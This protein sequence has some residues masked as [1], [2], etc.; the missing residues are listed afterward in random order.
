VEQVELPRTNAMEWANERE[1]HYIEKRGGVLRDMDE[2]LA[3]TLN[4]TSGGQVGNP[5]ARWEAIQA[6][7][8]HKWHNFQVAYQSFFERE[9]HGRVPRNHVENGQPIGVAVHNI[10]SHSH[11]VEG[12]LERMQWLQDRGWVANE[13][14]ARWID[15]QV[16]YQ[17][18]F[19]REGHGKVPQDH[20]ENGQ[21][22]GQSV[23]GIRSKSI[24]VKGR[25]E[26][27]QWLQ[28]RGW[29]ASELDA[30]WHDFQVAYQSFFSREGHGRVPQDHVENGQPIGETVHNIRSQSIFVKGRPERMQ[31]LTERGW[32]ASEL[33]AQWTDFQ[34]E[35]DLFFKSKKHGRVPYTYTSP[36]GYKLGKTVSNIRAKLQFVKG[37]PDRLQWLKERGF[38]MHATN[39]LK[40]KRKW[41]AAWATCP[42]TSGSGS[43]NGSEG[44]SSSSSSS[45]STDFAAPKSDQ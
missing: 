17:S 42:T 18:F 19:D 26:R 33:D 9:G 40:S 29:V 7:S 6:V 32:I 12:R 27:M 43:S 25:P 5:A 45:S 30:K 11:F 39:S 8:A 3:Q 13:L 16:V 20:V 31:W 24:F 41:E 15:F 34:V 28:D 38:V 37:K 23:S 1:R 35:F 21:P 4:L 10:R 2:K 22:I 44:S 36:S 14:D